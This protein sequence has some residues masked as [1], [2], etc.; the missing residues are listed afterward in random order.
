MDPQLEAFGAA[1]V[2]AR[3]GRNMRQEDLAAHVGVSQSH[4]SRIENGDSRL[5]E[6]HR[7]IAIVLDISLD[8]LKPGAPGDSRASAA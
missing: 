2:A 3:K 5:T 1:V 4:I 6:T 8:L 7:Q